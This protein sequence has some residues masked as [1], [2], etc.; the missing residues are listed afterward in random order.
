MFT[1]V[2]LSLF[3]FVSSSKA[4]YRQVLPICNISHCWSSVVLRVYVSI[5]TALNCEYVVLRKVD[6]TIYH[7]H[8]V[9]FFLMSEMNV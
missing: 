9:L 2:Y 3:Y 6:Y 8:K 1:F 7:I 4:V 5:H